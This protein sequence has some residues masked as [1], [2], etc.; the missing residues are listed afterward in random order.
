MAPLL[1]FSKDEFRVKLPIKI[2]MSL[3][4]ET[5]PVNKRVYTKLYK[6]DLFR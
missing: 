3:K 2:D 6:L 5:N 4:K 1:P